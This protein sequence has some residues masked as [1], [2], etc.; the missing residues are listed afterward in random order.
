M[1]S[2]KV[3]KA[4]KQTVTSDMTHDLYV[5]STVT[6]FLLY[7]QNAHHKYVYMVYNANNRSLKF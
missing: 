3:W 4:Q 2:L 7:G 5:W 6:V 1:N